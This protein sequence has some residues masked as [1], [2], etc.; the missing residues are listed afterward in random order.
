MQTHFLFKTVTAPC[1]FCA[2]RR[3]GFCGHL[4]GCS[5][6]ILSERA[7]VQ[8]YAEGV[9]LIRQ[10]ETCERVGII[11][12]GLVKTVMLFESGDERLLQVLRHGQLIG[13]PSGAKS[14]FSWEAATPVEV[15]W[16]SQTA[17]DAFLAGHP[18]RYGAYLDAL[19]AQLLS[20]QAS[21]ANMR[22]RGA[23]QRVAFWILDE[24]S[25]CPGEGQ[26]GFHIEL[27]RRDLASLLDMSPETLCRSLRQL[28]AERVI[29]LDASDPVKVLDRAKLRLIARWQDDRIAAALQSRRLDPG[30]S[31]GSG[32]RK[33]ASASCGTSSS[34]PGWTGDV[35]AGMIGPGSGGRRN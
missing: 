25:L 14:P 8:S 13:L 3:S 24:V 11:S 29:S 21:V 18:Q 19:Q 15:C 26:Q 34:E 16:M 7:T 30:T 6:D 9:A 17:W 28:H 12:R 10:D 33:P 32:N 4:D 5:L 22:G 2:A 23:L 31:A 1:R 27:K 20:L 35:F